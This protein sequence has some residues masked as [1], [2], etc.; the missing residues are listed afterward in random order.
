MENWPKFQWVVETLQ[1]EMP[2]PAYVLD[3]GCF[4]GYLLRQLGALGYRG[5]GVDLQGDLM[6]ALNQL[7]RLGVSPL[8]FHRCAAENLPSLVPEN[9]FDAVVALDVL[10]HC[11]DEFR[12]LDGLSRVCRPGGLLLFH[13][14]REDR[15]SS[16]HV[17]EYGE[18]DLSR[19][20]ARLAGPVVDDGRDELGRLTWR[21][22][23]RNAKPS[24]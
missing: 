1:R 3:V 11:L 7:T 14:P 16:E 19:L 8:S 24:S 20:T 22:W 23:G 18:S 13:L 9:T 2:A 10:E 21:V 6:R 15:D 4:T 12:A 17:R 5:L